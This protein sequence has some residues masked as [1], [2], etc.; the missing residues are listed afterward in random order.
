[1]NLLINESVRIFSICRDKL[2]SLLEEKRVDY[3]ELINF[4]HAQLYFIGDRS[5][6]LVLLIQNGRLWDAE[7]IMRPIMEATIRI[8]FVCY[9]SESE[10]FERINEFWSDFSDVNDLKRSE[11]AKMLIQRLGSTR[12]NDIG[13]KP[14][15]LKEL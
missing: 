10:R 9:S 15:I 12:A 5:Q 1:M 8:L 11:R 13:I 7:I 2:W 4:A 14:L 3:P 6:S